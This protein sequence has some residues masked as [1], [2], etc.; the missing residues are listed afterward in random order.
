MATRYG[1]AAVDYV[2]EGRFGYMPSLRGTQILPCRIS[3][4]V[5]VSRTVDLDLYELAQIFY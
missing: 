4:A 5:A 2:R 1:V 3:D